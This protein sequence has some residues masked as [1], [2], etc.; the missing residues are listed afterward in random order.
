M[1]LHLFAIVAGL[2]LLVWSADRFIAGAAAV[3]RLFGVSPLVIGLTIVALGTSAPE[4][5]VSAIAAL[6]AYVDAHEDALAA[7]SPSERD[8]VTA[9]TPRDGIHKA[10]GLAT[11]ADGFIAHVV[12]VGVIDVL[13]VV[14]VEQDG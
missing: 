3:A 1:A 11:G 2:I 7:L 13:E 5:F 14:D 8:L 10:R 4:M 6:Q 12:T 9:K